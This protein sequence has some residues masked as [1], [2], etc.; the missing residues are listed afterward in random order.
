MSIRLLKDQNNFNGRKRF[1]FKR[2]RNEIENSVEELLASREFVAVFNPHGIRSMYSEELFC[3]RG[4]E[5][6]RKN[7]F[8]RNC[9]DERSEKKCNKNMIGQFIDGRGKGEG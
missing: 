3:Q 1:S 7:K 6:K 4:G 5:N 9:L 2:K 8:D